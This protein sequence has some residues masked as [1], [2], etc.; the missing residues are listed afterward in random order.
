MGMQPHHEDEVDLEEDLGG[1]H[2]RNVSIAILNPTGQQI[3]DSSA[4]QTENHSSLGNSPMMQKRQRSYSV[5]GGYDD[6][7]VE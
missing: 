1:D 6:L 2:E 3:Q 7:F 4:R 5:Q